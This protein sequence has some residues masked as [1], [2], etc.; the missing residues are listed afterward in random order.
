DALRSAS[1][2][3]SGEVTPLQRRLVAELR[4]LVQDLVVAGTGGD[5]APAA[6][7]DP[8]ARADVALLEGRAGEAVSLL[9]AAALAV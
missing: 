4:L 9:V 2:G 1:A 7:A 8:F 3:W 6:V 5:G